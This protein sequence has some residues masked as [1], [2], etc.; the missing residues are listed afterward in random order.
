MIVLL[1]PS[2]T[3]DMS[4]IELPLPVS[5]PAFLE[6]SRV[7]IEQLKDVSEPDLQKLMGISPKLAALNH[8]R[9]NGFQF[10]FT[11]QNAKPAIFAFKGDVY[12]P[13]TLGSYSADDLAYANAH[14]RIL[15]GLYGLLRPLDLMQPYRLE[16]GMG[17]RN[18]RGKDLYGFWGLKITQAINEAL[19]IHSDHLIINLASQEYFKAVQPARLEGTLLT[20]NFLDQKG[21]TEPKIVGLYAKQARGMMADFIV[22]QRITTIDGLKLFNGNNYRFNPALSDDATL[23]FLRRH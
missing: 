13:L 1:S 7:L 15:S 10:P 21:T 23:A 19:S 4:A 5:Q 14:L 9:F 16:M 11:P 8:E 3:L 22:R 12:E 20:I 18:A 6:D 2:K 17:L